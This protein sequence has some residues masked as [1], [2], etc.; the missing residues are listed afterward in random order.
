MEKDPE[1]DADWEN[2]AGTKREEEKVKDKV[3]MKVEVKVKEGTDKDE[4]YENGRLLCQE[5]TEQVLK[6]WDQ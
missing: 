4:N 3:E 6:E 2:L 1:Q 5:V